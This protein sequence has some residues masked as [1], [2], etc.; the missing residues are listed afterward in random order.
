MPRSST[1]SMR[2]HTWPPPSDLTRRQH[3]YSEWD[4]IRQHHGWQEGADWAFEKNL[5]LNALLTIDN[6]KKQF[7]QD[8]ERMGFY[9][10]QECVVC[11]FPPSLISRG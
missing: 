4:Y 7:R 10:R 5:R 1:R 8:L 2:T 11:P 6:C 3:R 9:S